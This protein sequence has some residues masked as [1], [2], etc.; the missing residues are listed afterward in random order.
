MSDGDRSNEPKTRLIWSI[1]PAIVVC[2]MIIGAGWLQTAEYER[3]AD[4]QIADYAK[5]TKSKKSYGCVH[6]ARA[7]KIVCL[8]AA[9]DAY[10]EYRYNQRDLVAQKT[11]ALWAFIMG[12]AAVIGMALSA[13]GVWLVKTTFDETRKANDIARTQARASVLAH[14]A[15]LL[16]PKGGFKPIPPGNTLFPEGAYVFN[17]GCQITNVGMTVAKDVRLLVRLY[18]MPPGPNGSSSETTYQTSM[19]EI[20]KIGDVQNGGPVPKF[21]TLV[22]LDNVITEPNATTP[23]HDGT[24]YANYRIEFGDVF[25]Q[26]WFFEANFVGTAG[27]IKNERLPM[28]PVGAQRE[29]KID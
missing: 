24:F 10:R 14:E 2:A 26:R 19:N 22:S 15:Y 3:Q 29:G 28:Q 25:G 12:A 6:T 9:S 20:V 23:A 16:V 11:S 21:G 17:F 8:N 27:A 13:V 7:D 5:Y 18:T 4:K 1:T